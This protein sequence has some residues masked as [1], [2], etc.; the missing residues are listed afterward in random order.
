MVAEWKASTVFR[1]QQVRGEKEVVQAKHPLSS[2]LLK[3]KAP[4]SAKLSIKVHLSSVDITANKFD[5]Q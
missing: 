1:C 4:D 2:Q 5:K 3:Y